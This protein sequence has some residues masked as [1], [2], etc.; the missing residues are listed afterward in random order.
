MVCRE[1]VQGKRCS[2]PHDT[3]LH[4]SGSHY[5]SANAVINVSI[6]NRGE[7][8][9]LG[10][11]KVRVKTANGDAW[12]TVFYDSGS[13]LTLCLHKWARTSGLVGRP[14]QVFLCVLRGQYEA[15]DTMEYDLQ[16]VDIHGDLHPVTAVGLDR[17][18]RESPGGPLHLAM[19]QFP[20]I[21]PAE[22]E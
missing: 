20:H 21:P 22:L 2:K 10:I 5:C 3:S 7:L 9:L 1:K 12:A 11:Q 15:V 18:T 19:D 8:I 4:F 14:V 16:L 13:T 17:L 6:N